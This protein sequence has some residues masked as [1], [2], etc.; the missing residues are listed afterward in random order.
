[1]ALSGLLSSLLNRCCPTPGIH[2]KRTREAAH[3]EDQAHPGRP[4]AQHSPLAAHRHAPNSFYS[5]RARPS[6]A[7]ATGSLAA[8]ASLPMS[9]RRPGKDHSR[10]RHGYTSLSTGYSPGRAIPLA[11][12]VRERRAR[13]Q[14]AVKTIAAASLGLAAASGAGHVMQP[15]VAQTPARKPVLWSATATITSTMARP[16]ATAVRAANAASRSHKSLSSLR[17]ASKRME[18]DNLAARESWEQHLAPSPGLV[19]EML[20]MTERDEGAIA[21]PMDPVVADDKAL[22]DRFRRIA[23]GIGGYSAALASHMEGKPPRRPSL[24]VLGDL[25]SY[26]GLG[27]AQFGAGSSLDRLA[28]SFGAAA[29]RPVQIRT[30]PLA[31]RLPPGGKALANRS[32]SGLSA[33]LPSAA[34]AE[35]EPSVGELGEDRSQSLRPSDD[36]GWSGAWGEVELGRG[37]PGLD[38]DGEAPAAHHSRKDGDEEARA[39][40]DL[41]S[42]EDEEGED[43]GGDGDG[44]DEDE[45]SINLI[46]DDEDD[47]AEGAGGGEARQFGQ[48]SGTNGGA[49]SEGDEEDSLAGVSDADEVRAERRWHPRREYE[50]LPP[51][52]LAGTVK[53]LAARAR[54]EILE[55][56]GVP[57]AH[58]S[59]RELAAL[60]MTWGDGEEAC[61]SEDLNAVVS[62]NVDHTVARADFFRMLPGQW[63]SDQDINFWVAMLRRAVGTRSGFAHV[64]HPGHFRPDRMP[65]PQ[66]PAPATLAPVC[67]AALRLPFGTMPRVPESRA[68]QS[69]L[70]PRRRYGWF[71]E[72]QAAPCGSA[73]L[74]LVSPDA[75]AAGLDVTSTAAASEALDSVA[76]LRAETG[77]VVWRPPMPQSAQRRV[78]VAQC[79][80]LWSLSLRPGGYNYDAVRNW[81][82]KQGIDVRFVDLCVF[83]VNV[84][85]THWACVALDLRNRRA[86]YYDSLQH[87]SDERPRR[88]SRAARLCS[89]VI[90]WLRDE[91]AFWS[92]VG[93]PVDVSG[94]TSHVCR[95]PQQ[96]NGIDC[97]V[98]AAWVAECLCLGK[99]LDWAQSAVDDKRWEMIRVMLRHGPFL[100]EDDL[101]AS[102]S[103]AEPLDDLGAPAPTTPSAAAAAAGSGAGGDGQ[104]ARAS[105]GS[106]ETATSPGNAE[107]HPRPVLAQ[108]SP[109]GSTAT[110]PVDAGGSSSSSSNSGSSRWAN[111]AASGASPFA[112]TARP[113]PASKSSKRKGRQKSTPHRVSGPEP[114]LAS[115]SASAAASLRLADS[116]TAAFAEGFAQASS[117]SSSGG[118]GASG[119]FGA[120]QPL[121]MQQLSR[122]AAASTGDAAPFSPG[123]AAEAILDSLGKTGVL[124]F[125]RQIGVQPLGD[126]EA[127]RED[128]HDDESDEETV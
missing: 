67:R 53:E 78:F 109:F 90:R 91:T 41:A 10:P 124:E 119:I 92:D 121:M 88:G 80:H 52:A 49:E 17:T 20:W 28:R 115:E 107:S 55:P 95:T 22:Y 60:A 99:P 61:S 122:A 5:K 24:S 15:P 31:S 9:D 32:G 72:P 43:V 86:E 59:E 19:S 112:T 64:R 8:L 45:G 87:G 46:S 128:G 14:E 103:E 97:G 23:G 83:P 66:C 81:T 39:D 16:T 57:H 33:A 7:A 85:P 12:S 123:R 127:I 114:Q 13:P 54:R 75:D 37:W 4:P 47:G 11:S 18:S 113:L 74:A 6:L 42:S 116:A 77:L 2:P 117:S 29:P 62:R 98:F 89:D 93:G 35:L 96:G 110:Q 48:P 120:L 30:S 21:V 105:A 69:A 50:L 100:P 70:R 101:G 58:W 25:G 38:D 26:A 3:S 27:A 125:G 56:H 126:G 76:R 106:E 82:R 51:Q 34:G 108:A 68:T 40:V 1:M 111:S 94:F 71:E 63:L 102:D 73:R 118:A 44:E 84:T 36:V 79:L 65:P 104:Y